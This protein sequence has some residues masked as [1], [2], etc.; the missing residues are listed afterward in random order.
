MGSVGRALYSSLRNCRVV[1]ILLLESRFCHLPGPRP[2]PHPARASGRFRSLSHALPRVTAR[3]APAG[4][5]PA[6]F[7]S[8]A[9][10]QLAAWLAA[11]TTH[12]PAA[13]AGA[14]S[15]RCCARWQHGAVGGVSWHFVLPEA[16]ASYAR[17]PRT[18]MRTAFVHSSSATDAPH[19]L[20]TQRDAYDHQHRATD[21]C[22]DAASRA[23]TGR[24]R[25][26]RGSRPPSHTL[27]WFSRKVT[28]ALDHRPP[29][30]RS[31]RTRTY[32]PHQPPLLAATRGAQPSLPHGRAGLSG[33]SR[34]CIA[35][36]TNMP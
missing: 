15:P 22:Y 29:S 10:R 23:G 33:V 25:C 28:A 34:S 2:T 35:G 31:G 16:T 13:G 6:V 14:A 8:P 17:R 26:A 9:P 5:P 24:V 20:T 18:Q 11:R 27:A 32:Q 21:L 1:I 30:P 4:P 36:A 3:G 7:A 12:P 19:T